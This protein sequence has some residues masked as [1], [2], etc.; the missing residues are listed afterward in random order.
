MIEIMQYI[1]QGEGIDIEFKESKNKLNKDVYET[2]CA[3]LNRLGG[4]LI[5]GVKDN[6]EVVGIDENTVEQIKKD[7]ITSINNPLKMSPTFYT[8]V[9]QYEVDGKI[10]LYIYV[11]CSR[12]PLYQK[13]D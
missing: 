5:L 1:Q 4:H 12:Q 6:G 13:S 10:V 2:T 8:S 7:Y 9:Q 11:P 3:F